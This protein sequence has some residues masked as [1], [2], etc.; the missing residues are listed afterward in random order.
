MY[1]SLDKKDLLYFHRPFP[2]ALYDTNG[3][4]KVIG[5]WSLQKEAKNISP[6][7]SLVKRKL[8]V[9]VVQQLSNSKRSEITP[10]SNEKTNM[11]TRRQ[12]VSPPFWVA[13]GLQAYVESSRTYTIGLFTKIVD[14]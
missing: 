13:V 10:S 3:K 1:S 5:E 9:K 7:K 12:I 6:Y 11:K 2:L 14:G 8:F 4:V